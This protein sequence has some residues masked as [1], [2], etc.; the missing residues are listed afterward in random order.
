MFLL[1]YYTCK[2]RATQPL[3]PKKKQ[4]FLLV[5]QEHP[6]SSNISVLTS[7]LV[8]LNSIQH[9]LRRYEILNQVQDDSTT[10]LL[11]FR[12]FRWAFASVKSRNTGAWFPS[13]LPFTGPISFQPRRARNGRRTLS[14][15]ASRCWS[16]LRRGTHFRAGST[17][18]ASARRSLHPSRMSPASPGRQKPL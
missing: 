14:S 15:P 11:P 2:K 16:S 5:S 8:M 10:E 6:V 7:T 9:L 1:S 17:A 13:P 3:Q 4:I 18:P 12:D